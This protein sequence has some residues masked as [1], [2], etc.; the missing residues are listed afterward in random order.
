MILTSS[1]SRHWL[2]LPP[3]QEAAWP[4]AMPG[5]GL[6]VWLNFSGEGRLI[7]SDRAATTLRAGSMLWMQT[8]AAPGHAHSARRMS[9]TTPHRCLTLHYP[10]PWLEHTLSGTTTAMPPD[11]APLVTAPWASGAT[12]SRPLESADFTWA[13][14]FMAPHL[15]EQARRLLDHARLSEFLLRQLFSR[16][17]ESE[18]FCTRTKRL[19]QERVAQVKTVL[20]QSLAHPPSLDELASLAGCN[21]HYLSRT[22]SQMEGTP[23]SLWLRT[24]RIRRA[25]QLIASG[26]YNV[27]EA[28]QE[29]GYASLS[30]FSRAFRE[31]MGVSPS[32]WVTKTEET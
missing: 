22:F 27:S 11:L 12:A 25:A 23:L 1:P 15:C 3:G 14:S 4:E 7:W 30:H 24:Q 6:T 9:G 26:R 20:M 17:L 13:Q 31:E 28:G 5:A 8:S 21:P 2:R 32:Q 18:A 10:N 29:L 19:A 16:P